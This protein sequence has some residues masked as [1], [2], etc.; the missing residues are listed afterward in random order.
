MGTYVG[1][2]GDVSVPKEQWETHVAQM[3]AVLTQGGM[4]Q[5][6]TIQLYGKNI[7]LIHKPEFD[8]DRGVVDW[9][10]NYIENDYWEPCTLDASGWLTTGKVGQKQFRDVV[11]AAYVLETYLPGANAFAHMNGHLFSTDRYVGWLNQIL[12]AEFKMQCVGDIQKVLDIF[13]PNILR[14]KY[15]EFVKIYGE[16]TEP[17]PAEPVSIAD[18]L[19]CSPDDLVFLW[20][21]NGRIEFSDMMCAWLA[22]LRC[23]L[24]A[25]TA[26]GTDLIPP[27]DFLRFMVTVLADINPSDSLIGNFAWREMFFDWIQATHNLHVQ[28]SLVL[29]KELASQPSDGEQ[30][31]SNLRR[32]LAVLGNPALREYALKFTVTDNFA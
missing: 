10:Y 9:Q 19:R 1:V 16:R 29:L 15:M 27:S 22:S 12:G 21:P 24:D 28:A 3:L 4:M 30:C 11:Q 32:Y 13:P 20:T 17:L 23:R 2:M 18:F 7:M 5:Y 25:L 14:E 26:A 6:D 31:V 8:T